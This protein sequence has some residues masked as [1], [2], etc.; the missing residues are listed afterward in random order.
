MKKHTIQRYIWIIIFAAL[1]Y[2]VFIIISNSENTL[3]IIA[4][5][6]LSF[7]MFMLLLACMNYLIR[8]VKWEYL[9]RTIDV[10]LPFFTSILCF[11]SGFSMTLT[12]AKSGELI[13]PWLLTRFGHNAGHIAPV[14]IIERVTD[15]IGMIILMLISAAFLGIGVIP[16]ILLGIILI[17]LLFLIQSDRCMFIMRDWIIR[18]TRLAKYLSLFDTLLNSTRMLTGPAPFMIS[19]LLS[20]ISWLFECFCLYVALTGLGLQVH[21]MS[22]VFIFASA[23][24]AGLLVMIPGGLGATEGIMTV[25]IAAE[26]IPLD[27]A[28]S[29][30]LLTR[31]A[32]LWFAVGLGVIAL[33][34]FNMRYPESD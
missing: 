33:F 12:P 18:K 29:A 30:T 17:L 7:F 31:V 3:H 21:L 25:L 28:V 4:S 9:L 23:T 14:V 5:F 27:G 19:V 15:L 1:V 32:T 6:P 34:V 26:K 8:F 22:A 2:A 24:L 10:H 20:C 16:A 11:F 13:K